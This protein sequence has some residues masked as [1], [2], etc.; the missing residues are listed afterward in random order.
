MLVATPLAG[1]RRRRCPASAA[2]VGDRR[3]RWLRR[4]SRCFVSV[5]RRPGRRRD[6]V[7][8]RRPRP[9]PGRPPRRRPSRWTPRR[10]GGSPGVD[11][12]ARAFLLLRPY[13]KRAVQV[14]IADP[15]DPTPYWLVRTRHPDELAAAPLTALT[16]GRRSGTRWVG[17]VAMASGG[18][19]EGLD[20]LLAR[21]RRSARP[22]WQ[23]GAQHVLEG[24]DRQEPAGQPR[25][26]R[27]R[28]L[29]GRGLGRRQR[30]RRR[31]RPDARASAGPRSTTPSRPATCRP[32]CR[33]TTR[34]RQRD[35]GRD[36]TLRPATAARTGRGPSGRACRVRLVRSGAV[37]AD[38]LL[39]V[40]ELAAVVHQ[41]A[42]HAGE[43]VLL[44]GLHL[45]GQLLVREV[46]AGQLEGL[47]R[48]GL[49]L[50]DLARSSCRDG[51]P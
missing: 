3:S 13:L 22:R 38:Q 11:A 40:G 50:V 49:V 12:D 21:R 44:L 25:R 14:E 26:P 16:H 42:A 18:Q 28:H 31:A 29:G 15:A 1:L 10:P 47:G 19:L 34:T 23:E 51:A 8:P 20:G 2:W 37:A 9:H 6:G 45:D 48:L 41:E 4:W 46:G 32:S 43:L 27:R 30:H 7:L 33:R 36:P 17:C 35:R 24:R 39:L 5:R